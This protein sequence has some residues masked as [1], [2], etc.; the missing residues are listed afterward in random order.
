MAGMKS[1]V[2]VGHDLQSNGSGSSLGRLSRPFFMH[3]ELA[4]YF[5]K[6]SCMRIYMN[7]GIYRGISF[8]SR[9]S[10]KFV[11]FREGRM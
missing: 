5:P 9:L 4:Q 7:F 10:R 8:L 3:V 1:G 11:E 2:T 6:R